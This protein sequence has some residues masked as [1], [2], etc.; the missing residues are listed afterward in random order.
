MFRIL[1]DLTFLFVF[2]AVSVARGATLTAA[3]TSSS[4]S[5]DYCNPGPRVT[6][7]LT[8]DSRVYL[9][10]DVANGAVGDTLRAEWVRPDGVLYTTTN[11][12]PLPTAGDYCFNAWLGIAGQSAAQYPGTWTIRGYWNNA[13]FFTANFAINTPGGST[14]P[15]SGNTVGILSTSDLFLSGHAGT[16]NISDPGT[17]P[18]V[19]SVA[20]SAGKAVRFTNVAGTWIC[21]GG[22]ASNNADGGTCAGSNTNVASYRGIAGLIHSSKTMFLAGVFL[23]DTEPADPAPAR[24]DVSNYDTQALIQ[25]ALR[26]TFFIGNGV[27]ASG[28]RQEFVV[29]AGA[30]RLFLGV[31]DAANFQGTPCCYADNSGSLTAT[32]E[33]V[34]PTQSPTQPP[35][36]PPSGTNL[37]ISLAPATGSGATGQPY[38]V[39]AT[40]T[41]STGAPQANVGVVFT[42]SSG[43]NR[44][45][46]GTCSPSSCRTDSSG[47]VTFTYTGTGVAGTDSIVACTATGTVGASS[48]CTQ[49]ALRVAG[50]SA[51]AEIG[52]PGAAKSSKVV[53]IGAA[54][55]DPNCAGGA[56]RVRAGGC[57]PITGAAN[58]LGQFTFAGLDPPAVNASSLSPYDTAVLNVSSS[59]MACDTAK[60]S[61]QAK[62]DL[63]SFVGGGKKL[64]I[65]DS[66][67]Q[68]SGNKGLDYSW[69]PYPFTTANPGAMGGRGKLNIVENTTLGS[70][71]SGSPYYIDAANLSNNSDAVGDMNVMTTK[72]SHWCLSMSG[73]NALNVTGPVHAYAKYP[74]G[75]DSGLFIYNGLDQDDNN[76]NGNPNLRKLWFLELQQA[77]NPSSL[78]CGVAVV[79]IT[80]SV[81]NSTPPVGA[82]VTGTARVVDQLGQA[83][84]NITV[85]FTL[86]GVNGSA[87]GACSPSGCKTDA[88]GQV[89]FTYTGSAGTGVDTLQACFT[90]SGSATPVCAAPATITWGQ[91]GA[92]SVCST[93]VT[94]TWTAAGPVCDYFV[95]PLTNLGVPA[96]GTRNGFLQIFTG[97]QC[98]WGAVSNDTW[99]TI[100]AGAAGSG[101]PGAVSYS[102]APNTSSSPRT[103]TISITD[104]STRVVQTHT[105]VQL[106]GGVTCTFGISPVVGTAPPEGGGG[107]F[108]LSTNGSTCYWLAVPREPW[109]HVTPNS[110]YGSQLLTYK[111]DVNITNAARS[112]IIDVMGHAFTVFQAAPA[113]PVPPG[114]PTIS[115][116]GIVNAASSRPGPIARGSFFTIYGT[117]IGPTV[118]SQAT[119]YPIP[120]TAGGAVVT[121]AQGGATKRAYLHFVSSSQINGIIPSD[122]PL[123]DV[124]IT[125]I[126]NGRVGISAPATLVD[127]SFGIFSAAS[128]VG[129][130]I[131]QNWNSATDVVLNLPSLPGKPRQLAILWGTGLGP[132]NAPDWGRPPV[133][134][135]PAPVIVEVA[136]QQ[137]AVVYHG[138]APDFAGVDNIYFNVPAGVP[139]GCSVPVRVKAG[140]TWSNTVRMAISG[141]AAQ[142]SDPANPNAGVTA[143]G[144]KLGAIMLLRAELNGQFQANQPPANVTM[145]VGLGLF[146][147][148]RAGGQLAF[149]GALNLPPPGSCS[150]NTKGLDF[151]S[152]LGGDVLGGA[153]TSVNRQLDAGPKITVSGPR[154]SIDLS[155]L[156]SNAGT[157]MG[158]LGGNV[159]LSNATATPLFLDPR[160]TIALS[161]P[162]GRDVGAISGSITLPNTIQWTNRDQINTINRNTPLTI[163]WTGGDPGRMMVLVGGASDS[164][165]KNSGGFMCL[166]P[167]DAG[168]FTVPVS[169]LADL[170]A[171]RQLTGGAEDAVGGLGLISMPFGAPPSFNASGLD[172][173]MIVTGSASIKTVQIQ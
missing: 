153:D 102:V 30:T 92:S 90:P 46:S 62:A 6:T 69:L 169:I 104:G 82:Q 100:I 21:T 18:P 44:G 89:G 65:F 101:S 103:G 8:T 40:V 152:L 170:P 167:T 3:F 128:G 81:N 129:P 106:P 23:D 161:G 80:L 87:T 45:A 123:G 146:A 142:C 111:A 130:G 91:A 115:S 149:S 136:G 79:G 112:G 144:G 138:R 20:G 54:T 173:K 24:L 27:T 93:P 29:P 70:G 134:D 135:L 83:Q 53:I 85:T 25:P 9:Y 16:Q 155:P 4:S 55:V 131:I 47:R 34:T 140:P 109:L 50:S 74:S 73:T 22:A 61:T 52:Q 59:G 49:S 48:C 98:R 157:Y 60:L 75:T 171:T 51:A 15:P 86:T 38:T 96:A 156:G 145:D 64:I 107:T 67:C 11:V 12:N 110:G 172:S 158:L 28:T 71:V 5:D 162:G 159:P 117:D 97:L 160:A 120:D 17:A 68:A 39:T 113:P 88:N 143:S 2:F 7:F 133:G 58:E 122:A 56:N 137:A 108:L 163:T 31:V 151:T 33:I 147:E 165:S 121:I 116:G 118:P 148:I 72:D 119:S 168:T 43:P 99:I 114:T 37:S 66:E 105:V 57:L 154:G 36:T 35:V 150:S 13:A 63:V 78:P 164:K 166:V 10:V 14:T 95:Q 94:K 139:E 84:A 77:F 126:Y 19:L 26:Q 141:N 132:I 41:G 1:R 127:T 125:V 32:Y 76:N 42:V 124:Q